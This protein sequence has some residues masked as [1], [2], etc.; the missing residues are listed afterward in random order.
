M[1]FQRWSNSTPLLFGTPFIPTEIETAYG[2]IFRDGFYLNYRLSTLHQHNSIASFSCRFNKKRRIKHWP[3]TSEWLAKKSTTDFRSDLSSKLLSPQLQFATT[4]IR[5]QQH[6]RR[7]MNDYRYLWYDIKA[8]SHLYCD[9]GTNN[10][11]HCSVDGVPNL[12][13]GKYKYKLFNMI[14]P[15]CSAAFISYLKEFRMSVRSLLNICIL[16]IYVGNWN[17]SLDEG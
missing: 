14:P 1:V 17:S 11:R 10:T 16:R 13:R 4:M 15:L 5:V 8:A 9:D 7:I 2:F 3:I 12:T 6:S